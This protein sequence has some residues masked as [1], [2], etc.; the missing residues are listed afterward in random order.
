[1][2]YNMGTSTLPDK[3]A[4]GLLAYIRIRQST[5]AHAITI[6][7]MQTCLVLTGT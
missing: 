2:S 7:C 1:M 4:L 5:H 6:Q 3:Y